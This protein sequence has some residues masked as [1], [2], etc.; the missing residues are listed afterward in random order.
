MSVAKTLTTKD[1]TK[2][3]QSSHHCRGN[4]SEGR[5]ENRGAC[6]ACDIFAHQLHLRADS[7]WRVA[8][9]DLFAN[10][11]KVVKALLGL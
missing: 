3:L 6:A 5:Q 2:S 11:L 10:T 9:S 7:A 1:N 4:H 8:A